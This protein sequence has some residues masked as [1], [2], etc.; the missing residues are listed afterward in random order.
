MVNEFEVNKLTQRPT[1]VEFSLYKYD[2]KEEKEYAV[3]S[4]LLQTANPSDVDF[5]H[6]D[7]YALSAVF[8]QK[9]CHF[10]TEEEF[11]NAQYVALILEYSE[12][13]DLNQTK[14]PDE[15]ANTSQRPSFIET[16][17]E[18][19]KD[20]PNTPKDVTK[21]QFR[22]KRRSTMFFDVKSTNIQY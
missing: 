4:F 9:E 7:Q 12:E 21:V 22:D 5:E 2:M 15:S 3:D 18:T 16:P 11:L 1:R 6:P 14:K 20:T 8:V 19:H 13:E 10:E 17:K